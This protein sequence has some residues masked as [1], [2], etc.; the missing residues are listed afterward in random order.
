MTESDGPRPLSGVSPLAEHF[1]IETIEVEADRVVARMPIGERHSNPMGAVHGGAIISLADN[2]ATGMA[3]R[4]NLDDSGAGPFM[5]AIDL[6]AVLLSNQQGGVI[7]A[8]S[9]VVRRGR[10]VT[11]IR[12]VVRGAEGRTLAEVTTTHV[13]A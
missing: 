13:P 7:E 11:V 4:A 10:R 1:G 5:V 2:T 6:H 8:E 12:T 3:N 9:R